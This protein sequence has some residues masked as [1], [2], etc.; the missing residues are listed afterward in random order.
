MATGKPIGR[1]RKIDAD[2][3]LLSSED[4]ARLRSKAQ[5]DV[6]K[7]RKD[8]AEKAFLAQALDEER[9]EKGVDEELVTFTLDLAE[10]SDRI[11]L[12]SVHF[13]HGQTYT[14]PRSKYDS[15]REIAFRTWQHQL[16][17]DGKS[18]KMM[19]P[20]NRELSPSNPHGVVNTS[21]L[22]RA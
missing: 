4:K 12:D 1:P 16:E 18:K 20:Q 14:V 13:M 8:A 17:I 5:Q 19:R 11:V 2:M 9:R 22:M 21:H 3:T 10:F 15:M 6:E 7:E